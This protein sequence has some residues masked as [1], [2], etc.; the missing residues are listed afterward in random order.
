MEFTYDQ[1][2]NEKL[3]GLCK[4]GILL[5]KNGQCSNKRVCQLKGCDFCQEDNE[6]FEVCLICG[7]G[8]SKATNGDSMCL[9]LTEENSDKIDYC[10]KYDLRFIDK[11]RCYECQEGYLLNNSGETCIWD[12]SGLNDG[13]RKLKLAQSLS[14]SKIAEID[15]EECLPGFYAVKS[16]QAYSH[17]SWNYEKRLTGVEY[18]E[19]SNYP[20]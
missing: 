9:L 3:C 4:P 18:C 11:L 6:N 5:S 12:D 16:I 2:T 17:N 1:K 8:Y 14:S 10:E 13:C 20:L 7:K 19:F 15:C